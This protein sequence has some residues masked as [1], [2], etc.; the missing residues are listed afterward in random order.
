MGNGIV[1]VNGTPAP[2]YPNVYYIEGG[3]HVSLEAVPVSGYL[4]ETWSEGLSGSSNPTTMVVDCN[5]SIIANF[6]LT[7]HTL[8][9]QS[10]GNGS[11]SPA[12]GAYDYYDST[13]VS[14]T[15]TPD[16]GWQFDGWT[17]DV[18]N[19]VSANTTVTVDSDKVVTASFSLKTT[20]ISWP[21]VGGVMGGLI[22]VGLPVIILIVRRRA[23]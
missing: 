23:S 5:K 7:M 21:L 3:T 4:F 1:R 9:I 15:A 6:S 2:A 19:L 20:Q 8:T 14:I 13:V 16:S 17:G 22:L 12:M 11:T 18:S 10:S